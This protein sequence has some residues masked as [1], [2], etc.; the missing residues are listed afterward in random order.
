MSERAEARAQPVDNGSFAPARSPQNDILSK[1][2]G[3][4]LA[5]I[6]ERAQ[7]IHFRGRDEMF[8][9]GSAIDRVYF[10]QTGM[11]SLVIVLEDGTT[12]EALT[13]GRE[14]FIGVPLLNAVTT[15]RYRGICQIEGDFLA[16]SAEAFRSSI[17]R[18]PDLS[19]RLHRYSQYA[20]DVAAQSAAC[21]G[22]HRV[23]QRC[24]RWLLVTSDA[25]RSTTFTLTQ[26]FLAQML[27]VRRPGVTVAMAS[28]AK[29]ELISYRYRQVTLLDVPGLKETAC[30]CYATI[31]GRAEELLA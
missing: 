5:T 31:K 9:A 23:E 3:A 4:E 18:L 15:A 26:E 14:G 27:A 20:S 22:V 11:A 1:I 7:E 21:N 30:E 24:A 19:H 28:L 10:P 12:V 6:L 2:P 17:E 8:E 29:K 13:V 25:I 16:L